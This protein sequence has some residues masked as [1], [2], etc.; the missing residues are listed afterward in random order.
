VAISHPLHAEVLR[1]SMSMLQKRALWRNLVEAMNTSPVERTADRVR[2][3]C[4]SLEAGI[5]VDPVTLALAS[6]ATLF[7][8]G[9]AISDRLQEV[10]PDRLPGDPQ[11]SSQAVRQDHDL[12]LALAEA[13]YKR[14]GGVTEG[15]ALAHALAWT[16]ATDRA[17]SVL[18]EVAQRAEIADDRVRLAGVLA[19][20]RFWVNYD[21]DAAVNGLLA[22][23]ERDGPDCTP[24]V[25]SDVYQH[26][27]G[28]ALNTAKPLEALAYAR[29]SAEIEGVELELSAAAPP[30]AAALL[31]LGR[32]EESIKLADSA[33]PFNL[34][35][36]HPLNVAMLLFA[37]SGALLSG[38]RVEEA[39]GLAEWLR[40]VALSQELLGAAGIFGVLVGQILFAQ[41]KPVSASRI[42]RDSASL[43]AGH[44]IVGYRPWALLGLA[45]CNALL[46]NE[47]AGRFALAEASQQQRI[48]RN[49]E[50][51]RYLAEMEVHS[52]AGRAG[53]ALKVAQEGA[54]WARNAGMI[55]DEARILDAWSRLEPSRDIAD[56]LTELT[57]LTDSEMIRIMADDAHALVA[58][59]PDALL[60]VSDRYAAMQTWW[61]AAEAAASAATFYDKRDLTRAAKA[62]ARRAADLAQ[63]CEGAQT[64]ATSVGDVAPL[65]KRERQVAGLAVQGRSNREIAELMVL[66]PRTVENHLYRVYMKL[67]VTD[68]TTL[69]R[70]LAAHPAN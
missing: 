47:E 17:E 55:V 27:A 44:D 36:G 63:R 25:L 59:D 32:C 1:N 51:T 41:G 56:R 6:N 10:F 3:A 39:A 20:I 57:A 46:G 24:Q 2:L 61:M 45:R 21:V 48:V 29:Q 5:V 9:P 23:A 64:T 35:K 18:V 38:G 65:T 22:C 31:Y 60:A 66:S 12:G 4:W 34:E 15:V 69:A 58:R 8:I 26:L 11:A 68:R 50:G 33:V 13:A 37:K 49:Y 14:T 53:A 62:A 28:I 40:G 7:G 16:G 70:A 30:A 54:I 67:G 19:W 42:F 52:L 43:L